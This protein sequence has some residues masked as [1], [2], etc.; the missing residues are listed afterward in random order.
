M[1]QCPE[2]LSFKV[3]PALEYG[4]DWFICDDCYIAYSQS[5]VIDFNETLQFMRDTIKRLQAFERAFKSMQ[6]TT[7]IA[8]WKFYGQAICGEN[9]KFNIAVR[10]YNALER[11]GYMLDEVNDVGDIRVRVEYREKKNDENKES[12]F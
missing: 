8:G 11:A 9:E 7:D 2:C 6:Y 1:N 3:H 12:P 5:D 4:S 10:L